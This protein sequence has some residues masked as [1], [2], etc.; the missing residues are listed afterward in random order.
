MCPVVRGLLWWLADHRIFRPSI[1][2]AFKRGLL[3]EHE[4]EFVGAES[5][6]AGDGVVRLRPDREAAAGGDAASG[7]QAAEG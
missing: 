7:D 3:H 5:T 2:E 6:F 1:E 4:G